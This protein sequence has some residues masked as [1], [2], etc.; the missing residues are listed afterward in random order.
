[1]CSSL[2]CLL[3]KSVKWK[4]TQEC[5]KAVQQIKETLTSS[6]A[7]AH[8][9]PALPLFLA[10]DASSVGIGAMLFH[11]FEDGTE[12]AIAHASKTL[13]PTERNYSQIEQEA[14]ASI[15][16][17]RK[18]HQY[19][20]GRDF[21]LQTDHKPLTTIFGK[22]K[23]IPP[24]T[25]GRLQ[26]WASLLLGYSFSLNTKAPKYLEMLMDFHTCQLNQISFDR[27]N[28][29]NIKII[30]LVLYMKRNLTTYLSKLVISL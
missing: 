16:G 28:H 14:L 21:A 6:E 18:F 19:L 8:Y 9:N 30:E 5:K 4:W 1:M 25:A 13:T 17:V 11:R 29:G 26:R 15:Y 27:Q 12:K 20:W 3:Q 23:G 7:L 2:N 24:T 10:A 22:K